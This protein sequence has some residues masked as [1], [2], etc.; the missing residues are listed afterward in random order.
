MIRVAKKARYFEAALNRWRKVKDIS[1]T[2]LIISHDALDPA[3]FNLVDKIDFCQTK[4]IIHRY[5][6]NI[7]IDHH[8][9]DEP[10]IPPVQDQYGN[11]RPAIP[12]VN[13][14]HHFWWALNFI[15]DSFKEI[16]DADYITLMEEDHL[17]TED[18]YLTMKFLAGLQP[19]ICSDCFGINMAIFS[20]N[21][22]I[23]SMMFTK[24]ASLS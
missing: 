7:L 16:Q 22:A 6:G 18:F 17:V 8:P 2:I 21:S 1:K 23:I 20:A 24:R 13:M 15:F 19:E 3:M 14:K 9:G 4:Q 11:P 10:G 5:S 12:L